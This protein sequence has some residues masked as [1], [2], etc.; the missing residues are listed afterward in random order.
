LKKLESEV[1]G[2]ERRRTEVKFNIY[3]ASTIWTMDLAR[4]LILAERAT[5]RRRSGESGRLLTNHHGMFSCDNNCNN[6]FT[7]DGLSF[8]TAKSKTI[9]IDPLQLAAA[10]GGVLKCDTP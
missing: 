9:T 2:K 10:L 6:V 4:N 5:V 7:A 1:N 8:L 3:L